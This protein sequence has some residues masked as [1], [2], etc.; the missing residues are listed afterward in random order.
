[1][2]SGGF[3]F[4][5]LFLHIVLVVTHGGR[6][7]VASGT[8]VRCL[9]LSVFGA[10]ECRTSGRTSHGE[11]PRELTVSLVGSSSELKLDPMMFIDE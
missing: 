1:M 5:L 9:K 3:G 11:P 4:G 8:C 6:L 7:K 2:S 10:V